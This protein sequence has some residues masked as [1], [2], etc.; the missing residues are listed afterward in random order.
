MSNKLF[1]KE[2]FSKEILKD[3]IFY[4]NYIDHKM[5]TFK[6]FWKW[7]KESKKPEPISFPLA[8]NDPK[9]L[10]KKQNSKDF[11]MDRSCFFSHAIRWYQYFN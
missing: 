7:R 5:A 3:G 11:N 8:K 10:K 1:A 9:F 6:E 4:N 2:V